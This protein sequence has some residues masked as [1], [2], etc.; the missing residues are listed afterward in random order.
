VS[1]GFP[2]DPW[3]PKLYNERMKTITEIE[4]AIQHLTTDELSEFRKWFSD[5]DAAA[6]D[7]QFEEDVNHGKLDA[8]A[9]EALRD[10]SEGRCKDL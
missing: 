10:L 4:S 9:D 2:F 1:W 6:W 3:T 5:F 8:M 7:R